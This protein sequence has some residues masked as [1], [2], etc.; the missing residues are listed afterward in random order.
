MLV[1]RI[2][3]ARQSRNQKTS[4]SGSIW[5]NEKADPD[6]DPAIPERSSFHFSQGFSL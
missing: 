3:T 1:A 6:A 2:S 4:E 5:P